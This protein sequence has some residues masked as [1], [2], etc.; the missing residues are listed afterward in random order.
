MC[1]ELHSNFEEKSCLLRESILSA[2]CVKEMKDIRDSA[3]AE[4]AEDNK[5]L[6]RDSCVLWKSDSAWK[7]K[8][9]KAFRVPFMW[10]R[11]ASAITTVIP[12]LTIC[13]CICMYYHTYSHFIPLP[14]LVYKQPKGA[15]SNLFQ[16]FSC[17]WA[18][19]CLG[20]PPFFPSCVRS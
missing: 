9:R 5:T 1:P 20:V 17:W 11:K 14:W 16:A 18:V 10:K 12:W 6:P 3:L 4:A 15:V 7:N 13:I 2:N 19:N 8:N